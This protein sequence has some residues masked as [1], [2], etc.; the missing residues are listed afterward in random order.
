MRNTR[1]IALVKTNLRAAPTELLRM[2]APVGAR[3]EPGAPIE[4]DRL[5]DM[6]QIR[7]SSSSKR[8]SWTNGELN[9]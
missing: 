2:L 6:K 4:A 3:D 1:V 8:P 7:A 5:N 9:S